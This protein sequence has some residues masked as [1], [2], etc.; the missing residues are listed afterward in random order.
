MKLVNVEISYREEKV[1]LTLNVEG[2]AVELPPISRSES[3]HLGRTLLAAS[4][5]ADHVP[6]PWAETA[7][8]FLTKEDANNV[9]AILMAMAGESV[10]GV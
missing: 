5:V 2:V 8:A 7:D 3:A 9:G 4:V 1:F 10:L 6:A